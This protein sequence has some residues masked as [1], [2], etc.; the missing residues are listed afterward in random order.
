M[1]LLCTVKETPVQQLSTVRKLHIT[2]TTKKHGWMLVKK[3]LVLNRPEKKVSTVPPSLTVANL[4]SIRVLIPISGMFPK[5]V[6]DPISPQSQ[7]QEK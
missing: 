2:C 4:G 1:Y 7:P 6:I 3:C 5:V